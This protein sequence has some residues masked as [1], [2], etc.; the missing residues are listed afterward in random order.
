MCKGEGGRGSRTGGLALACRRPALEAAGLGSEG[1]VGSGQ[2]DNSD[3][4]EQQ[5]RRAADVPPSE[6]DAE[7]GGIPGEVHL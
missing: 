1:L 4:G 7:V 3:E 6:D 2:G 5:A